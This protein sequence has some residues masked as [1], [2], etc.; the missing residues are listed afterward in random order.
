MTLKIKNTLSKKLETF[1]PIEE[2]KVRFYQCGPTVYWNQHIGN[3]RAVT[4][5]D[6]VNRSLKYLGYKVNFVR[7]Y[8]DV[9]HL[10]GDN[11][12][13]A[14]TGEDRME[15]AAKRESKNPEEIA[16]F[17]ITQYEKDIAKMNTLPPT[18]TP[19][20]TKYI[21]E[22]IDMISVLLEKDFAYTTD[23]G[24]Y[25]DTSKATDYGR[26][27]GQKIG[28]NICGAGTGKV[29]DSNKKNPTDFALW[30]FKTGTHKNALQ[31][32][33][34]PFSKNGIQGFP[35]WHLE[36][37]AMGKKLLGETIDIKMGGIEHVPIHHTNEIAQSENANGTDYVHYWMHNEH[38]TVDGKKMSK[39]EGTSFLIS[40]IE[41][42]G[43]SPLDLR[44]FFLQAHYR[45]KQN[46][47]WGSLAASKTAREKLQKK[48]STFPEGGK[49]WR[50]FKKEF[51]ERLE[52]DFSTPEALAVV[53]KVLKSTIS[54]ANKKATILDFDKILGLRLA[55]KSSPK[56]S[57][58]IS[59]TITPEISALLIERQTA[60]SKKD[61]E[62][63]DK[64]RDKIKTLGY[65]IL[66]KDTE[67]ILEKIF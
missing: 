66:D 22:Q 14:D 60:R 50:A 11:D 63:S 31:T 67:Q 48:V 8:T 15:K 40:D 12:G 61:F 53:Y 51:I 23:L 62:S 37:S 55:K 26:L 6:F 30:F 18:H 19:K 17:Y 21:S 54:D 10:S 7:N 41:K 2:N 24:I 13:D 43:F 58:E 59:N 28:D 46:F 42:K 1:I 47:T 44:Y 49:V 65:K 20:A 3:M 36:C 29:S 39:S 56:T 38:L 57:A 16:N 35:G 34:S 52:D 45:S 64:I 4:L 33:E 27:S 5:A 25:F 9:G 32:W